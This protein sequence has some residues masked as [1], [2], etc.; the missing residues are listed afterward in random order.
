[1]LWGVYLQNKYSG[2]TWVALAWILLRGQARRIPHRDR[3]EETVHVHA[4]LERA[5][6]PKQSQRN[7]EFPLYDTL[8]TI[9]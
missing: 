5:M 7:V 4:L 3:S 9:F 1:M 8:M 2:L 6:V